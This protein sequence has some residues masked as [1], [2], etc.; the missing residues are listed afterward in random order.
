M[1]KTKT[2]TNGEFSKQDKLFRTCCELA[3][4]EPTKRQA[5]KFRR[6]F[7]KASKFKLEA[8]S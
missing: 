3:G 1:E 7:G 5:S 4:I 8:K 6:G 2:V